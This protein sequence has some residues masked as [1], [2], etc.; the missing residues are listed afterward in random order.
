MFGFLILCSPLTNKEKPN[1]EFFLNKVTEIE[2]ASFSWKCPDCHPHEKYVLKEIQNNTNIKDVNALATIMGNIKQESG[3]V[4]DICEGGRRM[5]YIQCKVGGY[6]II[7]WTT[8]TRYDGLGNFSKT[9]KC[10]PSE[11]KCQTKYMINE[12]IFQKY[13]PEFETPGYSISEYMTSAYY[14]LGWGIKGKREIYSHQYTKM[15][16]LS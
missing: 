16:V 4:S 9:Y 7:Q 6:G 5:P 13:L 15:F 10:N 2:K 3:F 11:L 12:S 1:P 8:Q 14:W